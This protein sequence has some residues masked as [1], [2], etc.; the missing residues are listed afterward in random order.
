MTL[1]PVKGAVLEWA[2]K[3]RGLSETDA[4]E[5][6][7]IEVTDLEDFE[8]GRKTPTLTQFEDFAAQYR[9]PQ[10]T[11][12]LQSPPSVPSDP[13]DFRSIDGNRVRVHS[14]D[15]N[16]ALSDIRNFL[17]QIEKVIAD[18]EEFVIP[19]LPQLTLQDD[20]SIEGERERR[21]VGITVEEQLGWKASKGFSNWRTALEKRG[22]LVFQAKF[23]INDG[24]GF[25]LYDSPE[26]P[27]VIINKEDMSDVAK[28]FTAWH[29]YA[30]LL[31][32]Q[33]GVSDHKFSDPTE[34]FCNRFAAA[35]L[36]PTEALRALL[37]VWPNSPVDWDSADI[38]RWAGRLKV[39]Q[40]ALAIRLEQLGLAPNGYGDKFAWGPPK[41]KPTSDG[42]DQIATHLSEIGFTYTERILSALDRGVIDQVAAIEALGMGGDHLQRARDYV[43]RRQ[44]PAPVA[45]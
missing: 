22:I 40:R 21:R 8:K 18:D 23:P 7:G 19:T 6:L 39:S 30:H 25:T 29:E 34:A 37:P 27:T 35:F 26:I 42:G 20:P 16:V 28:S 13:V 9:L 14:F 38:K 45:S 10:A 17:F 31:L 43:A 44:E 41:K 5:R 1:I 11:L 4:A 33:P 32:R 24:R 3:F 15:F 2:R 12:F 36:I